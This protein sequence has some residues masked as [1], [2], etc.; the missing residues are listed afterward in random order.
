MRLSKQLAILVIL[1]AIGLVILSILSLNIIK[2]NLTEARKH[3][4]QSIL[5]LAKREASYYVQ[6]ERQ[7]SLTRK[8]A[9]DKVIQVFTAMRAGDSYI[10]ANGNDARSKVHPNKDQLGSLQS[11]YKGSL[12]SLENTE[13]VFTV[14]QY[15]KAGSN[16]LYSKMNGM[17]KIPEWK[18]VFGYGIYMDDL[19]E[20]F[21]E[22]VFN[23]SLVVIVILGFIILAAVIVA[24]AILRNI[25]RNIGGEPKYVMSVTNRIADGNLNESIT[26]TFE[27]DSLLG[28]V[29]R[30]QTSL[31][32]MVRSIQNS[33]TQ[34]TGSAKAL[35]DQMTT[36]AIASQKSSESSQSTASAVQ[37]LST[38][39]EE[40]ADS[41]N[42]TERNSEA[43]FE[44][45]SRAENSVKNSAKS[46]NEISAEITSSS[47]EIISLQERSLEIGNI[48]SVIREIADQTNLLA[49]NAAIEA[50]RAGEQ[51]RG[52]AV[53]ADEVRTLASRTAAATAEI[54]ETISLVQSDTESVAKTMNAVLPKVETSVTSSEEVT[55]ILSTIRDASDETLKRI[56]EVSYS[57]EEQSKATQSL[58]ESAE[59]I[60]A[61][62]QAT[63]E[64]IA[65]SKLSTDELNNLALE[66]HNSVS[67][68]KL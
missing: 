12:R 46:I 5:T 8:E 28:S 68:F 30:M 65:N 52:F 53:V 55:E 22:I 9:E 40:I 62:I 44:M 32:N 39:I 33:S 20:D 4:I 67:Y 42:Q 38:S 13:F 41:V 1:S 48:I 58:A 36:I 11:G 14:G 56:R 15:P 18:W 47:S 60:S 25:L 19:D 16:G 49:L 64:A 2:S 21:S 34:L 37:Q 26:G 45:S 17:T 7:G 6:L 10:W 54:T 59:D 23:F 3:E 35:N 63:N 24:R 29:S 43:S 31:K 61:T 51:G 66:L 57:S 27:E 50:A